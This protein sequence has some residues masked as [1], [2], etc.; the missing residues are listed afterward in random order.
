LQATGETGAT[1]IAG[2]ILGALCEPIVLDD[3]G[4]L[5]TSV[6]IGTAVYPLH[7]DTVDALLEHADRLMYAAKRDGGTS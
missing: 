5:L 7:G 6:S 3:G 2:R 4:A 1:I